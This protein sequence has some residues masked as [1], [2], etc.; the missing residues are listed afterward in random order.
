MVFNHKQTKFF[1][2][3]PSRPRMVVITSLVVAF[4]AAGVGACGGSD[5]DSTAAP[6]PPSTNAFQASSTLGSAQQSMSGHTTQAAWSTSAPPTPVSVSA[7]LP[8]TS[9]DLAPTTGT[10]TP[11]SASRSAPRTDTVA[12]TTTGPKP[13]APTVDVPAAA[14]GLDST[15]KRRTEQLISLFEN[16]TLDPQYGHIARLEDGRGYTAGRAGFTSATGDLVLVVRRYIEVAPSSPLAPYVP[17]LERLA[18]AVSD[19]ISGLG[20]FTD[21]WRQASTDPQMRTVQDQVVDE[22][23]F[24]PAMSRAAA[25]GVWLPLALA[26]IY[27]TNIQHGEGTDPDGMPA[28][29]AETLATAGRPLNTAAAQAAWLRTFLAIRRA[30]LSHAHDPTTRVAWAESVGRLDTL[31]SLLDRGL[32]ML[33]TSFVVTVYGDVFTVP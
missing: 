6:M 4:A 8:S 31:G 7:P 20:G 26:T 13:T 12:G 21:H 33:D 23:Y 17:E 25:A 15:Q 29:L 3:L 18:I 19:D 11:T 30:H 16:S 27:D 14:T 9:A 5:G 2:T 32:V 22:V 10:T 24:R 28:I 1:V